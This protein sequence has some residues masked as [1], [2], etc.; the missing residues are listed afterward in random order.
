MID[1]SDPTAPIRAVRVV[2]INARPGDRATLAA[3]Y[4]S[5]WDTRELA[6]EFDVLGFAAP[7][8]V[9]RRK[10]DG[11]KGSLEFQNSPCFYFNWQEYRP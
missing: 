8:V 10:I 2:E 1:L 5:V 9:V 7:L 11:A 6:R 3:Q 4:G